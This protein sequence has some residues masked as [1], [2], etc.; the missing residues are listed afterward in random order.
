MLLMSAYLEKNLSFTKPKTTHSVPCCSMIS[1]SLCGHK[2]P[3]KWAM[4][5]TLD[6]N[7]CDKTQC[8]LRARSRSKTFQHQ[9]YIESK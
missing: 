6:H 4:L 7:I 2:R 3:L 5:K 8:G 1:I 9:A